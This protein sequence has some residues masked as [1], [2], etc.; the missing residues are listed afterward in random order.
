MLEEVPDDEDDGDAPGSG[1][2]A[3]EAAW[4]ASKAGERAIAAL[5]DQA[6][7][8]RR[9]RMPRKVRQGTR[10][11][12][13]IQK[14]EPRNTTQNDGRTSRFASIESCKAK[15]LSVGTAETGPHESTRRTREGPAAAQLDWVTPLGAETERN[16]A[17]FSPVF[18][19]G[20][21]S[22]RTRS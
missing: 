12:P 7:G 8:S 14:A 22:A 19:P 4:N 1:A 6:A 10:K 3:L 20:I 13:T 11:V 2:A 5:E 17:P 21:S 18:P 16:L 9:L 15:A